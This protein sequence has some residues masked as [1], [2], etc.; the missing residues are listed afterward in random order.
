MQLSKQQ[1]KKQRID[2]ESDNDQWMRNV[3]SKEGKQVNWIHKGLSPE[4]SNS[5]SRG[6][7]EN[8]FKNKLNYK[9]TC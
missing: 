4:G 7:G 8:T 1:F 5:R 3:I 2:G 6:R 9:A